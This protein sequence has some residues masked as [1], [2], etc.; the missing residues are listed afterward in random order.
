MASGDILK[1]EEVL[2]INVWEMHTFLA[3]KIDK[4]KLEARLRK[5]KNVKEL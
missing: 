1:V 2:K 3:H 5:G 4:Q